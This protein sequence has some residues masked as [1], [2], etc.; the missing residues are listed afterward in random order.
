MSLTLEL[1]C[2]EQRDIHVDFLPNGERKLAAANAE[3]PALFVH[4][5]DGHHRIR[6]LFDCD[7]RV[8][9]TDSFRIERAEGG[10]L[11]VSDR[12]DVPVTGCTGGASTGEDASAGVRP[13][14]ATLVVVLESPHRD[15]FCQAG[16]AISP[17]F[18]AM[19][20]TGTNLRGRLVDVIRS[21][22][23]LEEAMTYNSGAC[24]RRVVQPDSV[25]GVALGCRGGQ[26]GQGVQMSPE[27]H[28]LV[29]PLERGI[30]PLRLSGTVEAREPKLDSQRLR[31][32]RGSQL[33]DQFVSDEQS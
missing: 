2:P 20:T 4:S 33:G 10:G 16:E 25:S 27:A 18:P 24:S 1:R 11:S 31:A 32:A 9:D 22:P 29:C 3:R 5:E 30:N 7:K 14:G 13:Y 26:I 8:P 6:G 12:I 17:R 15:E 23:D 19:G 28:G 21:A